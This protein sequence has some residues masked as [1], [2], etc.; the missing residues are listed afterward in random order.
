M[1]VPTSRLLIATI[2][3]ACATPAAGQHV[4]AAPASLAYDPPAN[5]YRS[6][7][8]PPE[9]Y[10]SNEVNAG[11]Q[12]YPFRAAPP[13]VVTGFQ[14]TLLREWI[15]PQYVEGPLPSAPQ[16]SRQQMPGAAMV[17]SVHFL[18]NTAGVI[19]KRMRILIVAGN[20][21]ALVDLQANSD[22]SWQRAWPAMQAMLGSMRVEAVAAIAPTA[23]TAPT[24][25]TRGL[26]GIYMGM[27]GHYVVDLN[28]GVGQGHWLTQ[29]HFYLFSSTGRVY[30]TFDP[31]AAQDA[32]RFDYDAAQ[33]SDPESSGRYVV[34]GDQMVIRMMGPQPETIRLPLPRGSLTIDRVTYT[35]Q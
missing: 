31:V 3:V 1:L 29:A 22:Y 16:F 35:R 4:G 17:L 9:Q 7:S 20:R 15:D 2:A 18:Q 14:R 34:Q 11:I 32:E 25:A 6:A 5:F 13:D 28:A 24:G 27:K 12:V 8:T 10:S 26:A 23:P 33:R 30:R 21:A 19:T